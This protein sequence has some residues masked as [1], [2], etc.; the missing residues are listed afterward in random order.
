MPHSKP[1]VYDDDDDAS[2]PYAIVNV[3]TQTLVD[4]TM[5]AMA[6]YLG[7]RRHCPLPLTDDELDDAVHA[8]SS[9]LDA[10]PGLNVSDP[11]ALIALDRFQSVNA[12][13]T[14][15]DA[16]NLSVVAGSSLSCP[17]DRVSL[18]SSVPSSL[19]VKSVVTRDPSSSSPVLSD[20]HAVDVF[21]C[22][23]RLCA[24]VR[25]ADLPDVINVTMFGWGRRPG[26]PGRCAWRHPP[27]RTWSTA[28]CTTLVSASAVVCQ[29]THLTGNND[30]PPAIIYA[31]ALILR[32]SSRSWTSGGAWARRTRR[33]SSCTGCRSP[34]TWRC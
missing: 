12:T 17:S 13:C 15:V 21:A 31:R 23:G 3:R 9:A 20:I 24:E 29:C 30:D 28:G 19:Y 2:F 25:V 1:T 34:A 32:Q 5:R 8:L 10:E 33:P 6:S 7:R 4:V 26:A 11:V 16:P 18:P 14:Q 27:S 22:D